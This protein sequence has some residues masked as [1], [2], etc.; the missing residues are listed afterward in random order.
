MKEKII[1]KSLIAT[2]LI[3]F[4]ATATNL[5]AQDLPPEVSVDIEFSD[6][7]RSEGSEVRIIVN[8]SDADGS[9]NS[10][11]A[12]FHSKLT[13]SGFGV[14]PS[15]ADPWV[16]TKTIGDHIA[17]YIVPGEHYVTVYVTD[18]AGNRVDDES[19]H[20]TVPDFPPSAPYFAEAESSHMVNAT[21]YQDSNASGGSAV[22]LSNGGFIQPTAL[23]RH[24]NTLKI[25]YSSL[26]D[27]TLTLLGGRVGKFKIPLTATG[28]TNQYEEVSVPADIRTAVIYQIRSEEGDIAANIDNVT[29]EWTFDDSYVPD[30]EFGITEENVLYHAADSGFTPSQIL[31]GYQGQTEDVTNSEPVLAFKPNGEAYYRY[32][33]PLPDIEYIFI[34]TVEVKIT[35]EEFE[36]GECSVAFNMIRGG[37][38]TD[39]PCVDNVATSQPVSLYEIIHKPT[40]LRIFSCATENGSPVTASMATAEDCGKWEKVDNGN[41][42]HLQNKASG[43]YIRPET[44]AS[45]STIQTQPNTWTGNWTQWSLDDRGDGYG[46]L[47]NRATGKYIFIPSDGE[48]KNIQQQPSS[49]RGDYTRFKL[50]LTN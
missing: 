18:D 10:V 1:K 43:K 22:A 5:Y 33:Y 13:V 50:Q 17:E 9:I 34:P 45:G 40:G 23:Q 21:P 12:N 14:A 20:F 16:F 11:S 49:W 42:F 41:F 6:P 7:N 3:G 36:G 48:G 15:S 28:D 8:A 24:A 29:Y 39:S 2:A 38:F 31:M 26:E 25:R 27:G 46:H 35:S 47:V 4:T 44:S 19:I 32:E 37:G 30:Y